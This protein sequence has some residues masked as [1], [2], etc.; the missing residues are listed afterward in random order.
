MTKNISRVSCVLLFLLVSAYTKKEPHI[1][2][3]EQ[4]WIHGS[5]NCK[6]QADPLIQTVRYDE[7]TWIFRQNKCVHYEAPFMYL[8]IGKN[9]ALLVDTGASESEAVF[10]LY[11]AVNRII[12]GKNKK[13]LPLIVA[14]TH[15]HSDHHAGDKQFAGKPNTMVVGLQVDEIKKFFGI[16][17]WPEGAATL[18]LGGRILDIIPIPGHHKTSL[19]FYDRNSELLLTGDTF[20]PG[21]LYVDNWIAFK[22][23]IARLYEFASQH[24]V[25]YILGNH[26]EMSLTPEVDYPTGTTNQPEEQR[27]PLTVEELGILNRSLKT[28]TD[29]PERMVFGKFIV[30]PK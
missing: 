24:E 19:A 29:E 21:R 18:D 23:S 3:E 12:Q 15:S 26:I 16:V 2:L 14:H 10:P 25:A 30:S 8:F 13:A 22:K 28:T 4:R 1:L 7:T 20:Y 11:D 9:K 5:E 6:L 17:Q 27:L